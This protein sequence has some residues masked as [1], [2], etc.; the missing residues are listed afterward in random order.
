[1]P[2]DDRAVSE[3]VVDEPATGGVPEVGALGAHDDV[4]EDVAAPGG[5]AVRDDP[6]GAGEESLGAVVGGAP[7][8]DGGHRMPLRIGAVG[9]GRRWTAGRGRRT[10]EMTGFQTSV[11]AV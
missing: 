8:G 11:P 6:L 10:G 4:A 5:D 3:Q 7:V 9:S 1:V 2:D